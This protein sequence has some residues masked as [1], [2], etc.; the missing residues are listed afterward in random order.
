MVIRES[1]AFIGLDAPYWYF[2]G[3]IEQ[4][5]NCRSGATA[6]DGGQGLGQFMP[7]TARWVHDREDALMD[8]DHE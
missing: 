4:E 7:A 2:M 8:A 3:Q 1:R 6:F 5:S